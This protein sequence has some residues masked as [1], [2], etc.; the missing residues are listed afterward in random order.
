MNKVYK[1]LEEIKINY[2]EKEIGRAKNLIGQ[3]FGT[4]TIL[5]R[6]INAKNGQLQWAS[7]CDCGNYFI[8]NGSKLQAKTQ[9]S[10]GC[11]KQ[12]KIIDETGNKYGSLTVLKQIPK[13]AHIKERGLW[14]LC[15]CDCGNTTKVRGT[16]LRNGKTK[17]CGCNMKKHQ[18]EFGQMNFKNE[19]GNK[20]GKLTVIERYK[21][22]NNK[23]IKTKWL[24]QCEC[25]NTT[26]V[27][28]SDLRS[29]RT[30]SC[31][32]IQSFGEQQIL[33]YLQFHNIKYKKEYCFLDLISKNNGYPRF[34]FA[35]F[36][37]NNNLLFLIEYQGIQHFENKNNFG[38]Y[39]REET[40]QLKKEYCNKNNIKLYYINYNDNIENE[41]NKIFSK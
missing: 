35:V 12:Y 41:L 5:Y 38:K 26:I 13:P 4:L 14:W 30:K 20:Y 21:E 32:C 40:D 7:L 3:K 27:N 11:K 17:S 2:P 24:C 28:A 1:T 31:G 23:Q 25:G 34:D 29:G 8:A 15:Q 18:H 19:I 6:T 10:C 22:N 16:D 9:I 36:D 39:Q 37:D 33:K